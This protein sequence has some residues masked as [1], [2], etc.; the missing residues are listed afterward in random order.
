VIERNFC[1]FVPSAD[2]RF[3]FCQNQL[4][5][6]VKKLVGGMVVVVVSE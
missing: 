2:V 1:L 3:P 4:K 6:G 5:E